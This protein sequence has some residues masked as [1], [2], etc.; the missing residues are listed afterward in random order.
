[1]A[2]KRAKSMDQTLFWT[3]G[4]AEAAV[5][6]VSAAH[7]FPGTWRN[8]SVRT[9]PRVHLGNVGLCRRA[10]EARRHAAQIALR[11]A[12]LPGRLACWPTPPA[13]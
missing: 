11:L 13:P 1:M 5:E 3:S 10:V 12:S 7:G 2:R 4:T 9:V 6:T 8:V